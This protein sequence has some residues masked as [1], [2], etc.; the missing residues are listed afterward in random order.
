[1]NEMSMEPKPVN[2]SDFFKSGHA[3]RYSPAVARSL[4][5]LANT[6]TKLHEDG[7]NVSIKDG[8]LHCVDTFEGHEITWV[9]NIEQSINRS[10]NGNPHMSLD[11][12][13][14]P[15]DRSLRSQSVCVV[16]SKNLP[17]GDSL[18]SWL[19][20]YRTGEAT[21]RIQTMDTA[22]RRVCGLTF[23]NFT[24]QAELM[25][26]WRTFYEELIG[27]TN[28]N[29]FDAFIDH[30]LESRIFIARQLMEMEIDDSGYFNSDDR[31]AFACLLFEHS[32]CHDT[33]RVVIS[34]AGATGEQKYIGSLQSLVRSQPEDPRVSRAAI[35]AINRLQGQV[36]EGGIK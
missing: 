18:A 29:R 31:H 19:L 26:T 32:D 6:I 24:S 20:L 25:G 16:M 7:G 23:G 4:E 36:N 28:T 11:V 14:K 30:D 17:V 13:H 34:R 35:Y 22:A 3:R 1:M 2:I 8:F 33:L 10:L 9:V 27:E 21:N 15:K 5:L 12:M